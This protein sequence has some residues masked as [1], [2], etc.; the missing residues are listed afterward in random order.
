MKWQHINLLFSNKIE[1]F[2]YEKWSSS[3]TFRN[4]QILLYDKKSIL[5]ILYFVTSKQ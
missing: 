5:W 2:P 3:F 1:D 4:T